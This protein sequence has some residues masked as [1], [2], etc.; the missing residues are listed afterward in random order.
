MERFSPLLQNLELKK[1]AGEKEKENIKNKATFLKQDK[2]RQNKTTF[3]VRKK[4]YHRYLKEMIKKSKEKD[5]D[6][7]KNKAETRQKESD[8]ATFLKQDKN[9]VTKLHVLSK[10]ND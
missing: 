2:K 4:E 1:R 3:L 5:T 9:K 7:T 8:N 10:R 6:R